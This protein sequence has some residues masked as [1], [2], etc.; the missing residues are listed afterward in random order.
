VERGDFTS[1]KTSGGS[2]IIMGGSGGSG[3]LN[4]VWRSDDSGTTWTLVNASSGWNARYGHTS[5]IMPDGDIVLTG[6]L[7]YGYFQD[8]FNIHFFNDVWRSPDNGATWTQMTSAAEW[9]G[10]AR[11]SSVVMPDGSIVLMGGYNSSTGRK[12][13]VWRSTDNGATWT[14]VTAS[15]G[16]SPRLLHSS[17]VMPDGTIVLMG[18]SSS[19][20]GLNDVWQSTDNGATWTQVT[21]SAEWSPRSMFSSVVMPDGSIV[22]MGGSSEGSYKNDVWRSTDNG[23][24]WTQVTAGAEWS[25][26]SLYSSVVMPDGSI[27]LMGGSSSS[28]GLNDVWRFMPAGST[29]QNPSH[30]YTT[31]GIYQVALQAYNTGGYNSM[32]RTGYITVATSTQ[33]NPSPPLGGNA[34]TII[35]ANVQQELSVAITNPFTGNWALSQGAN[36]Q[37]YGNLNVTANLPWSL[38]TSATNGNYLK[39]SG[40]TSLAANLVLNSV[41]V[42]SYT[43]SGTGSAD[44][45][46]DFAQ[47]INIFDDP[48][49]Y[50]TVVTFTVNAM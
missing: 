45:A 33:R 10:R 8:S 43:S 30:T 16:W 6:G 14:Q 44:M 41:P 39:T 37:N 32:R 50:G 31:P 49:N 28:S 4:D 25:P 2:I 9:A 21:A 15:A 19:S 1:V 38:S 20:S 48:G 5:V 23:A 11:H 3:Y 27:V 36:T 7:F 13:D 12:N 17:V 47:W 22:L 40:G 35:N 26:R 24:T 34:T 42:T 18:G 29:A 46:L